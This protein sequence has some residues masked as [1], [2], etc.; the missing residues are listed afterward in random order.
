MPVEQ[1]LCLLE[2]PRVSDRTSGYRHAIDTGVS[3]H[4]HACLCREKIPG[5][6]HGAVAC[7]TFH[8]GQKIPIT[9]TVVPLHNASAMHGNSRDST[10]KCAVENG[11]KLVLAIL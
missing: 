11:E 5:S 7:V 6:E 1:V 3:K 9:W 8:G 4:G 2:D 10:R